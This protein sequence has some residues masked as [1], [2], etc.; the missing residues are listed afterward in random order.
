[1]NNNEHA[2]SLGSRE[3]RMVSEGLDVNCTSKGCKEGKTVSSFMVGMT[4]EKGV[5]LCVPLEKR[6]TGDYFAELIRTE[7]KTALAASGKMAKRILQD[8]DPSQN[9]KKARDELFKQNIRLFSIP[10]RSPDLEPIENLFNLVRRTIKKDSLN[11]QLL[12]ESKFEFTE[13]VRNLLLNYDTE[14]ID[15]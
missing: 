1:M 5:V 10:P 9:S 3:W 11:Q 4:Y 7:I 2:K 6:I 13:R 14:R 8:G 15:N 12:R